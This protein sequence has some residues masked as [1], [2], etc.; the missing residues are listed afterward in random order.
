MGNARVELVMTADVVVVAVGR[1]RR[2][3]LLEQIC[4]GVTQAD[5]PHPGVDQQ[6]A[7]PPAHVPDVAA[8]QLDEMWLPQQSDRVIDAATFEP[9]I[10]NRKDHHLINA[11]PLPGPRH[12]HA[13]V[14]SGNSRR[15]QSGGGG[16]G[17]SVTG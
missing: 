3:V 10:G 14:M 2:R 11:A 9:A 8:H 5:Q 13:W 6:A 1:D 7:V 4:G 16:V 17:L 15:G 12:S